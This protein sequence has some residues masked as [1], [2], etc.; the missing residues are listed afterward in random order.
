MNISKQL[1]CLDEPRTC[2]IAN[3]FLLSMKKSGRHGVLT[4][5]DK[6]RLAHHYFAP[7]TPPLQK[8]DSAQIKYLAKTLRQAFTDAMLEGSQASVDLR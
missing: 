2:D 1:L 8:N 3:S 6:L 4:P 5:T 7:T